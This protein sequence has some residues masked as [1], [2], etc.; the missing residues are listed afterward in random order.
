M[1]RAR[2][3]SDLPIK[4]CVTCGRSMPWRRKVAGVGGKTTIGRDA[5]DR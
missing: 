3:T 2:R 1:P 4:T 5:F